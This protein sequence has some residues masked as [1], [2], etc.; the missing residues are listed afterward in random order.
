RLE[1]RLV[2]LLPRRAAARGHP[3][4]QLHPSSRGGVQMTTTADTK[5][6][7][8]LVRLTD[9]G[10]NYGNIIALQGVTLDVGASE[11]T[12]VLGD[13]GAGKYTLIKIIVGVHQHTHGTYEVASASG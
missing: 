12:C 6:E 9:A 7:T 3:A 1:P 4:E 2:L 11:V 10:K 5:T 8:P 13:N